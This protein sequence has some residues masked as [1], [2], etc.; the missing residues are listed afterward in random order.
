MQTFCLD[1]ASNNF[2]LLRLPLT[3]RVMPGETL[4]I[5][6]YLLKFLC[7][8]GSNLNCGDS[9]NHQFSNN[10]LF[11]IFLTLDIPFVN[12]HSALQHHDVLFPFI[13][14]CSKA[15]N[16]ENCYKFRISLE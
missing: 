3:H 13:V 4:D 14:Q 16:G 2:T 8:V 15:Y 5:S 9:S 10:H 12:V 6:R 7:F 1:W 11:F